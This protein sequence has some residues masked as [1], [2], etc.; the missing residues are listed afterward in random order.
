MGIKPKGHDFNDQMQD[1]EGRPL[2]VDDGRAEKSC[3]F[4]VAGSQY[5]ARP[6]TGN[7]QPN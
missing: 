4:P 1:P 6:A 3:Q 7:R 5:G 2:H